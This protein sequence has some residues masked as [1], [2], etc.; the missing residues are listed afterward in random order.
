MPPRRWRELSQNNITIIQT[1]YNERFYLET[2]IERWNNF[3]TPVN[4]ILIDDGSEIEPAEN[5][6]K[7]H[8][9]NDNINFSLYRVTEDIG[10][11]GHG[12]R[13]LGAKLAKSNWLLF[14]DID[15]TIQPSDLKRL[16]TETL[17]LNSWYQL[18][19][20]FQGRGDTYI[21]LNQYMIP[22]KLF[23]D[24]GGYDESFVPFHYGDR[25]LLSQLERDYQKINIDWMF[26]TCRR[27]GRKIISDDTRSIP[28]YDDE[29][30]LLYSPPFDKESIVHKDTKLNFPWEEIVINR[31]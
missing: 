28:V 2:Q 19:A 24:S 7:E 11:N 13:N 27:G 15:Y 29:N 8:T 22:R 17:D 25:E 20:K 14:L 26:L 31:G 23:L 16:Q 12:C 5:V 30:M 9:L 18:N 3:N 10:F 21:A 1:Y 6:L 4:I